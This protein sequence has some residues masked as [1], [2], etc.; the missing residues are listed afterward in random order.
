MYDWVTMPYSRNWHNTVNQ[1]YF[2]KIISKI[3]WCFRHDSAETNLTCIHE[4]MGSIPDLTQWT[5]DLA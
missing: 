2:N 5:K 4:N 3:P 1:L